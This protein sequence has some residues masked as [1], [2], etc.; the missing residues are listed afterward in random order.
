MELSSFSENVVTE[1]FSR[2]GEEVELKINIDAIVPDYFEALEER[3]K[4]L[5]VRLKNLGEKY[6]AMVDQIN[7]RQEDSKKKKKVDNT[8]LPST[9]QLE[10]EMAEIQ[11]EAFA[12]RLTCAIKLPDG[13]STQLLKGWSIVE[14]GMPIAPTKEALLRLPP[15]LVQ[16]LWE[17][18][19]KR[20]E[21]VKK[22]DD[23]VETS[24]NTQDGSAAPSG[25]SVVPRVVGQST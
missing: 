18:C 9:I 14:N 21:T 12:E 23:E 11:R 6:Q 17:R 4:P 15:R 24:G 3:L 20:T 25:L 13:T 7:K 8:P 5:S 19:I 10:K 1:T 22:T 16:E 2:N